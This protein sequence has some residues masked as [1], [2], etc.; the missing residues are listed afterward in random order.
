[1]HFRPHMIPQEHTY[2]ACIMRYV[3]C[4][5]A[6]ILLSATCVI[7]RIEGMGIWESLATDLAGG[8]TDV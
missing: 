3:T 5:L 4:R 7:C 6:L 1:M 8:K 2:L